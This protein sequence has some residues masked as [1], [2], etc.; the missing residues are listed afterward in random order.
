MTLDARLLGNK[1]L[2]HI[3]PS[4]AL[5]KLGKQQK[6]IALHY[7]GGAR[8]QDIAQALGLAESTVRNHVACI[9][10]KCHVRNKI[11]LAAL[12]QKYA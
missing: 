12:V 1:V 10:K 2:V 7:A 11:E 5:A 9:F 3:R 4:N 8:Y 6:I